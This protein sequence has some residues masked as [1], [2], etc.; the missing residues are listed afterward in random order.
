VLRALNTTKRRK[1]PDEAPLD[2]VPD[3][4]RRLVMPDGQPDRPPY[5]LCVLSTL[6][7]ALRSGDIYLPQSRRSTAPETCLLPRVA[8]PHLRED[9]CQPLDLD[10]TGATRLSDRAQALKDL[11]PRV[12]RLLDQRAGIRIEQG[13]WIV[14]M[15]EGEDIPE[16]VKALAEQ[17]GRR[18]PQV[19]LT[20]LLLEVDPWTGFSQHL[21]H[22]GGGQPRTDDL[23]RHL[24]AAVVAQGT[25]RV[26]F[27]YTIGCH[28]MRRTRT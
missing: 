28:G 24:H 21:T 10:P 22:A 11:L 14:P 20:A 9:V 4:W 25:N 23:L 7:E 27:D 5:E 3:Q 19:D 6:R 16:S 13:E 8:W 1:L 15:E 26:H 17:S 2:F 18:L 12:D